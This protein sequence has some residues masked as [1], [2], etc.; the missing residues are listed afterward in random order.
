[1]S[2]LPRR[3]VRSRPLALRLYIACV[4]AVGRVFDDGT[5]VCPPWVGRHFSELPPGVQILHGVDHLE[6]LG[7]GKGKDTADAAR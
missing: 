5:A 3:L 4:D 7:T 6:I 2:R 1:M